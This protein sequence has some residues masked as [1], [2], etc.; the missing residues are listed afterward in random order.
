MVTVEQVIH[1]QNV[2]IKGME[3]SVPLAQKLIAVKRPMLSLEE[4]H[5]YVMASAR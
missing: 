3:I 5:L 2:I 4:L 1:L